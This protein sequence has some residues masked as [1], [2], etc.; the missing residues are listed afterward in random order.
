MFLRF[1]KTTLFLALIFVLI[2]PGFS[3][4]AQNDCKTKEE[5][6]ALLQ[7][8]EEEIK[9]LEG[10]IGK[11]EAEQRTIQGQIDALRGSIQR[12]DLQ[13]RQSNV[14]ITDLTYQIKDTEQSIDQTSLKIDDLKNRLGNILQTIYEEEQVSLIEILMSGETL[15]DF[16]DNL[17]A[18]ETLNLKSYQLLEEIKGLKITLAGQREN[19]DSEKIDLQNVVRMQALQKQ[20]SQSARSEQEH[21]LQLTEAQKQQYLRE[22]EQ[23]EKAAAE[24]RARIFELAGMPTDVAAPTFGEAYD[25]AKRIEGVTGVRPAF[26]LA[27]L[28][29]ESAIGRNVGQCYLPRNPDEIIRGRYMAMPPASARNDV[30]HFLQI[31]QELGLDPYKT[32]ISCP[33]SF[34]WGGAMGPAQFIPTTWMSYKTRLESILGRRASPWN[35]YDAFLAS[36]LYLSDYGARSQTRD[37][38]WRA[39]MIY[40]SGSTTNPAFYFYADS[41]LNIAARFEN[42]IRIIE[43]SR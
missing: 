6:E 2:F 40:F 34:G 27:I 22:K 5:C 3:L 1:F 41:V 7:R 8:Y 4:V 14:M 10:A 36:G 16:F 20:Q 11:T 18:L 9:Q 31:T 25:I 29:Q 28:Q 33:M 32:P 42:D 15:S 37:G 13:I 23:A 38:E 26:L 21:F 12:L 43:S 17:M 19:L 24:I 39:A 30:A 35:I